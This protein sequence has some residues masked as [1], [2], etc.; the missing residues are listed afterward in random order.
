[1]RRWGSRPWS[2]AALLVFAALVAACGGKTSTAKGT[3]TVPQATT[4]TSDPG[5]GSLVRPATI[6]VAYVQQVIDR[7]DVL[8][9]DAFRA[10]EADRAVTDRVKQ[11]LSDAFAGH[12]LDG[13]TGDFTRE[14]QAGFTLV[15]PNPGN[16]RTAVLALLSSSPSCLFVK[17]RR[18]LADVYRPGFDTAFEFVFV[19][20]RTAPPSP[21]GQNRTGW[22]VVLDGARRDDTAPDDPCVGT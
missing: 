5:S 1:M 16:P 12:S 17:T 6:D 7:L 10:L 21:D 9:G 18:S 11:L 13:K 4:S 20:F 14:V 8:Y 22:K 2:V 3:A 19:G 15:R